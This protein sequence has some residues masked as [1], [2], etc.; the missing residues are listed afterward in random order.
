MRCSWKIMI[1][2][3]IN[4][5][6]TTNIAKVIH[7]HQQNSDPLYYSRLFSRHYLIVLITGLYWPVGGIKNVN[8]K[9]FKKL[10]ISLIFS[11]L[12][13]IKTLNPNLRMHNLYANFVK[14]PDVCKSFSKKLVKELGNLPR[15]S[16]FSK[17]TV[18]EVIALN[19]NNWN[20]FY[21]PFGRIRKRASTDFS[22]FTYQFIT[23]KSR[24]SSFS[25][26]SSVKWVHLLFHNTYTLSITDP[27]ARSSMHSLN[28]TSGFSL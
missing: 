15:P 8:K 17:F 28:S 5:L 3:I 2:N 4:T 25:P 16:V 22:Q 13:A 19:Q 10:R 27:S 11:N 14:I 9:T 23:T 12:V 6:N 21:K 7:E 18:P 1:K 24:T 26:E 20:P